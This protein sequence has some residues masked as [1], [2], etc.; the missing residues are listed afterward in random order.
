MQQTPWNNVSG[1]TYA[2]EPHLW[3]LEPDTPPLEIRESGRPPDTFRTTTYF[4]FTFRGSTFHR[5][6]EES[7][8]LPILQSEWN[9][10]KM[11]KSYT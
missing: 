3:D 2:S 6:K 5:C 11:V 10:I 7:Q 8:A 1:L 4:S 9:F